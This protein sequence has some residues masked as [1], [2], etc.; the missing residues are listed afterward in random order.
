MQ[1]WF[2]VLSGVQAAIIL[3]LGAVLFVL[4][5]AAIAWWPWTLTPL[6]SAAVGAWLVGIGI[7]LAWAVWEN[8]WLRLSG[9]MSTDA[10]LGV[11]QLVAVARYGG[12]IDWDDPSAWLYVALLL[13]IVVVGGLGV[14]FARR[15]RARFASS[16]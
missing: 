4:P 13:S 5:H 10:L 16:R 14:L 3:L 11:L 2:R 15:A 6:T 8:D 7:T 9:G 12:E 1:P